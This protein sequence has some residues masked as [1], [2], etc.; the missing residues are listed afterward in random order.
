M[1]IKRENPITREKSRSG[2]RSAPEWDP[3]QLK[4]IDKHKRSSIPVPFGV[5]RAILGASLTCADF[6]PKSDS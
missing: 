5:P 1:R 2:E 6:S 3:S 4:R